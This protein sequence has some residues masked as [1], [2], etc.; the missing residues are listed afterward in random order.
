[1]PPGSATAAVIFTRRS[2]FHTGMSIMTLHQTSWF[3]GTIFV[4]A[5]EAVLATPTHDHPWRS[6][7]PFPAVYSYETSMNCFSLSVKFI[8]NTVHV[9]NTA[10]SKSQAFLDPEEGWS[11]VIFGSLR[12][13]S[14][15]FEPLALPGL[16]E[17]SCPR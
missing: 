17:C 15:N 16:P 9:R 10:W 3:E 2:E 5:Y 13:G 14:H 6:T 1:M 8:P 12:G 4:H 7:R 11:H